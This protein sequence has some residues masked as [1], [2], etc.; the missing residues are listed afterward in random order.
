MTFLLNPLIYVL[1]SEWNNSRHHLWRKDTSLKRDEYP[2]SCAIF[3]RFFPCQ[4]CCVTQNARNRHISV[5]RFACE[6]LR[7]L[8]YVTWCLMLFVPSIFVRLV[9]RV[10]LFVSFELLKFHTIPSNCSSFI[11]CVAPSSNFG[12]NI[13]RSISCDLVFVWYFSS[14][15]NTHSALSQGSCIPHRK[16]WMCSMI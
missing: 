1:S 13:I 10:C 12:T 7:Q 6:L 2:T 11:V 5:H 15:T 4:E 3:S 9:I 14:E 8:S 16:C